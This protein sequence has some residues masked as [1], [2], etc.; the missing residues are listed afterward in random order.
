MALCSPLPRVRPNHSLQTDVKGR[1]QAALVQG[2][3]PAFNPDTPPDTLIREQFGIETSLMVNLGLDHRF[4]VLQS[5]SY[6]N[7]SCPVVPGL[8]VLHVLFLVSTDGKMKINEFFV[9]RAQ[10]FSLFQIIFKMQTHVNHL[11]G[12]SIL[13]VINVLIIHIHT[14]ERPCQGPPILH[15]STPTYNGPPAP[16]GD[17]IIV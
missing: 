12:A 6:T 17:E 10:L 16:S 3:I 11:G 13:I 2:P 15:P 1:C 9:V 8:L 5:S 14:G 4:H 7:L